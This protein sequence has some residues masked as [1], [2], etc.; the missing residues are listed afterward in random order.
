MM[1]HQEQLGEERKLFV[2][3]FHIN[4]HHQRKSIEELK[5][6]RNLEARTDAEAMK[7]SVYW[8]AP[9]GLLNL[10]YYKTQDQHPRDGTTHNGLNSFQPIT[11]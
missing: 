2:L 5:Q 1:K 8:I 11:N 9:C 6:G 10:L 3:Y 7:G 4:F